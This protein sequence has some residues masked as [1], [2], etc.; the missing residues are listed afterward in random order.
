MS[1]A[2]QVDAQY[3]E[4]YNLILIAKNGASAAVAAAGVTLLNGQQPG[5]S[6]PLANQP[7]TNSPVLKTSTIKSAQIV[8][9]QLPFAAGES[10][11]VNILK[12]GVSILTAP[13]VLNSTLPAGDVLNILSDVANL[14]LAAGSD[15][16]YNV[17][18]VAG[19]TPNHPNILI[20]LTAG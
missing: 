3:A 13:V 16:T 15:L 20:S 4:L 5:L 2:A 10:A 1:E 18:Y 8:I 17:N 7:F 11:T 14:A 12:N 19:S 9:G 6:A